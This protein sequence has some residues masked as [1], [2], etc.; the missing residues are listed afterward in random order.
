MAIPELGKVGMI[1]PTLHRQIMRLEGE[2]GE[3][4]FSKEH[5]QTGLS[6]L[7]FP[8]VLGAPKALHEAETRST[9]QLSVTNL[10]GKGKTS[11]QGLVWPPHL[12]L[13]IGVGQ[14]VLWRQLAVI[15]DK[16]VQ[17]GGAQD[18][19]QGREGVRKGTGGQD[20]KGHNH[21]SC[22]H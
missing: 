19:L 1:T 22:T 3:N 9:H 20:P 8:T 5:S 11:P 10:E 16:V 21:L 14:V 17:D 6:I 15:I 12:H 2:G 4:A 13:N 18:G 7:F